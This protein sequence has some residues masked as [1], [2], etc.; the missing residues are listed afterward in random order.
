MVP[1]YL[2]IKKF[3]ILVSH[4]PLMAFTLVKIKCKPIGRP[5]HQRTLKWLFIHWA[6]QFICTHVKNFSEISAPLTKLTWKDSFYKDAMLAFLVLI[7]TLCWCIYWY[8]HCWRRSGSYLAQVDKQ[9]AFHV[10]LYGSCQ[11][12]KHEKNY[13]SYLLE[14]AAAVWGMEFYDEYLRGKHFFLY[15]DH[16]PLEN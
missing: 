4:S 6:L 8:I 16:K 7:C 9:G 15:T 13:S 11:L 3:H 1:S 12:V 10:V 14:M 5:N 2:E